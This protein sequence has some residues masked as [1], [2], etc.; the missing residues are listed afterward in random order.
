MEGVFCALLILFLITVA[1]KR[2]LWGAIF[3]VALIIIASFII[4]GN[5]DDDP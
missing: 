4:C 1:L 3:L 5:K 2:V